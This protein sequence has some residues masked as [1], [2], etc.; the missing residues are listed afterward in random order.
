MFTRTAI[1][2]P[3]LLACG[4]E[5][6][7]DQTG[8][9]SSTSDGGEQLTHGKVVFA[10][11]RWEHQAFDPSVGTASVLITMTYGGCLG[12]FYEANPNFRQAGPDGALVF[13]GFDLG[14]EGW[15]D[16]LC[17]PGLI[18]A[19]AD[20]SGVFIEQRLDPDEQ[21]TVAYDITGELENRQLAFGPLP[22]KETAGCLDPSVRTLVGG[23]EGY[24]EDGA[25]MWES[26][27]IHAVDALT[28]QAEAI[29]VEMRASGD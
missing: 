26:S 23:I 12:D 19:Q 8:D 16:R 25:V 1:S 22:T 21:L 14:G 27:S 4:A 24:S 20:C 10:F 5:R 6:S 9:S 13:G 7:L 2:L 18:P 29:A 11:R 28:D 17:E 15:R 3:L